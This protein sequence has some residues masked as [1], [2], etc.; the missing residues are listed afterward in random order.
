MRRRGGLT[1]ALSLW[2]EI[3]GTT[4]VEL[5][6][7]MP[8]MVA[9]VF[10]AWTL[11]VALYY[12]EEAR[13]AVEL[14]SRIYLV[15]ANATTAQLQTAVASHLMDIPISSITLTPASTTV[16]GAAAEVITW[17]YQTSASIPF[18]PA[19]PMTF[20]SSITVPAAAS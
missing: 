17:S 14:G 2:A 16:G 3:S 6:M 13:H 4:A 10:G 5:A 7:V 15:N 19:I 9:C 20:T 1:R 18:A 12:G 8:V 11:G